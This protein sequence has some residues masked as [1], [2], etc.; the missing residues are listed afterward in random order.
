MSNQPAYRG[1]PVAYRGIP[2]SGEVAPPA[3][4]PNPA[5]YSGQASTRDIP[6]IIPTRDGSASLKLDPSV[7][8]SPTMD[9]SK[10]DSARVGIGRG[11]RTI[12]G[13]L[14]QLGYFTDGRDEEEMQAELN[15]QAAAFQKLQDD[16]ILG[17]SA[18]SGS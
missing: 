17:T 1:T 2:E 5:G 16:P 10:W 9:M 8:F 4:E 13:G 11:M 3:P 15:F 14:Q 6:I 7:A 18:T 12:Y